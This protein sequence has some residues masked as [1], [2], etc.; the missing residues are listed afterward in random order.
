MSNNFH[1][2]EL[3][4]LIFHPGRQVGNLSRQ[5]E[6]EKGKT[7]QLKRDMD[8][9]KKKAKAEQERA[10]RMVSRPVYSVCVCVCVCMR[11]YVCVCVCV[12]VCV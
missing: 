12:C 4:L 5:L 11:V 10:T 9:F 1:L 6:D 8:N 2:G 7:A 3:Y